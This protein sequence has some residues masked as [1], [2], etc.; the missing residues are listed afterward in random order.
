MTE[1]YTPITPYHLQYE[2]TIDDPEV[3]TEPWTISLPLY[4]RTEE[5]PR[6]LE[7]RCVEMVEEL[8]YGHL[9][10]EQLVSAIWSVTSNTRVSPSQRPREFPIQAGTPRFTSS[11]WMVRPAFENPWTIMILSGPCVTW[12]GNGSYR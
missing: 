10:R 8:I 1:R 3:F 7:Y 5:H 4:R 6:V 11:R 12:N 9:R 2:A